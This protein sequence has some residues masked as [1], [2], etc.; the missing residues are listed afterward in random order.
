[1]A[2]SCAIPGPH[3]SLHLP[4][5]PRQATFT[6]LDSYHDTSFPPEDPSS[7]HPPRQRTWS[8]QSLKDVIP[9]TSRRQVLS[10]WG[11]WKIVVLS[12]CVIFPP[13]RTT[14][15]LTIRKGS[16][17]SLYWFRFLCVPE[18]AVLELTFL[19]IYTLYLTARHR[20][21][22]FQFQQDRLCAYVFARSRGYSRR[23]S[24]TVTVCVFAL[25]PLVQV[26]CG[27]TCCFETKTELRSF[28]I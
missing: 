3:Q 22:G 1:M 13:S 21:Y 25:I 16:T 8:I 7:N 11:G 26:G 17:F 5:Q 10:A 20:L 12:S 4:F 15:S 27:S 23:S 6:P 14:R 28:M 9:T 24:C 19:M 2:A 18:Y